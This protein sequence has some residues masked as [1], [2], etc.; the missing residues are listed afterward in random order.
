MVGL[1]SDVCDVM[2][3]ESLQSYE[4]TAWLADPSK[5]YFTARGV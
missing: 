4:S 1:S 5:P 3:S 2:Q